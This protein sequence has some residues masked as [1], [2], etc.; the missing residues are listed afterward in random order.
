M[1]KKNILVP[2]DFTKEAEAGLQTAGNMARRIG[3]RLSLVHIVD[4]PAPSAVQPDGDILSRN[5]K[6]KEHER[7]MVELINKRNAQLE[8]LADRF[9]PDLE[10][11][12]TIEFGKFTERLENFL[13]ENDIDL[14]VMGTSGETNISEFFSGNHAAR[15]VR[16]SDVPVLAVKDYFELELGARML[17]LVDI[18][19][20][21]EKT[22][23]RLKR[24]AELFRLNI[25]FA[26]ARKK[27]D[28]IS[29]D[30][31]NDLKEI[32]DNHGFTNYSL[33]VFDKGEKTE[34]IKDFV[35]DMKID[36][37]ASISEGD[38]GL[39]RLIFGSDTEKFI[40]EIDEPIL[41][42]SE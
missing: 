34:I 16:A 42:I 14:I 10:V 4:E 41:A 24:F 19:E 30:I 13:T 22:M 26:H 15:A 39:V 8:K 20:Y 36:L 40:N 12:T 7:F 3:A 38:S 37:I 17:L 32:A 6:M 31:I 5:D 1:K 2:I 27:K 35:K 11:T 23:F 33:H 21:P 18:K 25:Y 28:A 29:E 9:N